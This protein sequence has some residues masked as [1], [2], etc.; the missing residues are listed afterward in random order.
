MLPKHTFVIILVTLL[1]TV[2]A[3]QTQYS[4][5]GNV[6]SN[7][8]YGFR[9][10]NNLYEWSPGD[11]TRVRANG[12]GNILSVGVY[13]EFGEMKERRILLSNVSVPL[14]TKDIK[15]VSIVISIVNPDHIDPS[16]SLIACRVLEPWGMGLSNATDPDRGAPAQEMD[17]TW[18][19]PFYSSLETPNY[20]NNREFG[21]YHTEEDCVV[22]KVDENLT[23]VVFQHSDFMLRYS[24]W[25]VESNG[26]VIY[27]NSSRV[28]TEVYHIYGV[29]SNKGPHLY[30]DLIVETGIPDYMLAIYAMSGSSVVFVIVLVVV[31]VFKRTRRNGYA[32]LQ[33]IGEYVNDNAIMMTSALA[34][35][36]DALQK[37]G[38]K[39]I[40]K[41]DLKYT[42]DDVIGRG[43]SGNVY[44]ASLGNRY[45]AVKKIERDIENV[46]AL[47]HLIGEMVYL[48][49][50][51]H[52]HILSII[53][54]V[55]GT[56]RKDEISMVVPFMKGGTL[57]KHIH[58]PDHKL[59]FAAKLNVL[60]Q[61]ATAMEYLHN[62]DPP[63]LH[64]DL[65]PANILLDEN[66]D[67]KVSDFGIA[68]PEMTQMTVL[69]TP[70]YMA[71][72]TLR[73]H[74][75][76]KADVYSYA[77]LFIETM[78]EVRPDASDAYFSFSEEASTDSEIPGAVF[79]DQEV[80]VAFGDLIRQCLDPNP[81][82]RPSFSQIVTYL[83]EYVSNRSD[84]DDS[85]II[86]TSQYEYGEGDD[87]GE[88]ED[89]DAS[90]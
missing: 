59:D 44:V 26:I 68:R 48:A 9:K 5:A 64:R 8:I 30:F 80:E 85:A 23:E 35:H 14:E 24:D 55:I 32:P 34:T 13:D 76:T 15:S 73:G 81:I 38:I 74:F 66:L 71:P 19:Y 7:E 17:A 47:Q 3:A 78:N 51:K 43:S 4:L 87:V 61:V 31:I 46:N 86:D 41:E 10:Q 1:C 2:L 54:I 70:F 39:V 75:T 53:G 52:E 20:W 40:R 42:E 6:E 67:C 33:D 37:A 50:L 28:A 89:L 27:S 83:E 45:V 49:A 60:F 16:L 25:F 63:I 11:G 29:H 56:G 57:T 36:L 12:M 22:G 18:R 90:F 62:A 58:S 84:W 72:E 21:S 69:G 82:Y 88:S 79:T 65:K 77:K